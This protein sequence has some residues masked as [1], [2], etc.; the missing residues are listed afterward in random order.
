[1][2]E[3]QS[4]S[5]DATDLDATVLD[6]AD[7]DAADLEDDGVL[8]ASDTLE[9]DI[10]DDPLDQGISA[11]DRWSAAQHFGTTLDEERT[12]ESLDQLL[13]EEEP[14]VDPHRGGPS[15]SDPDRAGRLVAD[16]AGAH[17]DDEPEL[18]GYDVGADGGAPAAEELAVHVIDEDRP[19]D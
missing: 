8:D 4:P 11:P 19:A 5:L 17:E 15:S 10:G 16:D 3:D 9:G 2:T 6:A 14:D 13:A 7:L 12:G 18:V 1:M